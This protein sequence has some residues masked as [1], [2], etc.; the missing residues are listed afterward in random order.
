[1]FDIIYALTQ[2][3]VNSTLSMGIY[4]YKNAFQM[5]QMDTMALSLAAMV[6]SCCSV[7]RLSALTGTTRKERGLKSKK[8]SYTISGRANRHTLCSR[9]ASR[10]LIYGILVI[11]FLWTVV[12][13]Y[14]ILSN[15][16]KQTLDIKELPT[17][18]FFST[19]LNLYS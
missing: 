17:K 11:F 2:G 15:S 4:A 3:P 6:S 1:M 5:Y 10:V 8:N 19:T 18:L 14:M 13:I 16:F 12:P 9:S 7:S